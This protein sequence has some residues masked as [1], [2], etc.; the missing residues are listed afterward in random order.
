ML[1]PP[2]SGA[3][4]VE[5]RGFEPLTPSMRMMPPQR[6]SGNRRERCDPIDRAA[7][8]SQNVP[9]RAGRTRPIPNRD[10]L[11][12]QQISKG[13]DGGPSEP[14]DLGPAWWVILGSTQ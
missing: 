12:E 7:H 6:P 14:P 5:L 13:S 9:V 4:I 10:A 8:A 2:E 3:F 1:T 11:L